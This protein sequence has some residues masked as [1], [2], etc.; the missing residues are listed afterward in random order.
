MVYGPH[1]RRADLSLFKT[2]SIHEALALQFHAECF[3]ISNT[4]N[5]ALPSSTITHQ[6][7]MHLAIMWPLEAG[8]LA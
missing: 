5:V 1:Q 4:A 3:N 8:T 6:H 2:I 7:Q